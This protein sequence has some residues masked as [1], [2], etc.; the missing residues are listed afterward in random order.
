MVSS[1]TSSWPVGSCRAGR[2][3]PDRVVQK[4]YRKSGQRVDKSLFEFPASP[5]PEESPNRLR[6]HASNPCPQQ[7]RLGGRGGG[8]SISHKRG[9]SGGNPIP[10]EQRRRGIGVPRIRWTS[11]QR[12]RIPR[13]KEGGRLFE[14]YQGS[15]FGLGQQQR[16]SSTRE[17][18]AADA[19]GCSLVRSPRRKRQLVAYIRGK[20]FSSWRK[21]RSCKKEDASEG[22]AR[23][24][25]TL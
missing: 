24:S 13:V 19:K 25:P 15:S 11:L 8:S 18:M 7:E 20:P 4:V 22:G 16:S 14:T 1:S 3:R 6:A 21:P 2:Q 17:T 9:V 23:A 12:R 5:P 10:L